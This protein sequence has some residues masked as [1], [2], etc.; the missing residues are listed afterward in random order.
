M[1]PQF[2]VEGGLTKDAISQFDGPVIFSQKVTS[3]SPK[4]IEVNNIFLQ[5]DATVSR[6]ITVGIATP[7]LAGN[8]GDIVFNANPTSGGY[9]GWVFTTNG[10]WQRFGGVSDTTGEMSVLFD[11][12]GVGTTTAGT[13]TVQIGAGSSMVAIDSDGVGIGTT[14]NGFSLHVNGNA[15]ITGVVT[16]TGGFVGITNLSVAASGWTATGGGDGYYNTGLNFVG[17]GTSVPGYTLEVGDPAG[18]DVDLVVNGMTNLI[19]L[20]TVSDLVVTGILTAS[21]VSLTSA[22][23]SAGIVTATGLQVGSAI[24]TSSN[25][26]G[27]GT[28][29]PRSKL[30]V[31]GRTRLKTYSEHVEALTISSNVVTIDLSLANTFTLDLGSDVNSFELSNIP[32]DSTEFTVKI[33]QDSTGSRAVGIDTFANASTSA[34]IPVYWPGGGVLPIVTQAAS[35]TDIYSFKTFD[36]GS[37]LYGFVGGQNFA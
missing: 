9:A 17:I 27:I 33:T 12:V 8:A 25:N 26:V 15:N 10:E 4:G 18:T 14:A 23:V 5:G 2:K 31:E 21:N 34:S 22:N 35:R 13:N 7:A 1:I 11:R 29:V 19:G 24:T 36:G 20:T 32:D 3:I 16:A 37:T 28:S 30:D 6:N